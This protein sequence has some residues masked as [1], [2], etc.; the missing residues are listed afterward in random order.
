MSYFSTPYLMACQLRVDLRTPDHRTLQRAILEVGSEHRGQQ[1]YAFILRHC[2]LN[3]MKELKHF[4]H[5]HT[6]LNSHWRTGCL[7]VKTCQRSLRTSSHIPR[8]PHATELHSHCCRPLLSAEE[9]LASR[10]DENRPGRWTCQVPFTPLKPRD[11][12]LSYPSTDTASRSHF[13]C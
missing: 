4:T 11:N 1:R 2:F 3:V 10:A 8:V 5:L 13:N 12:W 9:R 7:T 6:H